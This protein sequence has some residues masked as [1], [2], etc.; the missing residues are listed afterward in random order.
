[1]AEELW[2]GQRQ[3][4]TS[5]EQTYGLHREMIIIRRGV[6]IWNGVHTVGRGKVLGDDL[7]LEKASFRKPLVLLSLTCRPASEGPRTVPSGHITSSW[8]T[9]GCTDRWEE[10]WARHHLV[11]S[12]PLAD[13]QPT[14]TW[15]RRK[16]G[17]TVKK[18]TAPVHSKTV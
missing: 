16:R 13:V 7:L 17:K 3:H 1:M 8:M 15:E 6:A 10:K 14:A 2:Q 18:F 12:A 4:T 11:A 9:V 5:L